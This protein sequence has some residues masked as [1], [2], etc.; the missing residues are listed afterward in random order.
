MARSP[1]KVASESDVTP[2]A[3]E[4]LDF[5]DDT[6]RGK[7]KPFIDQN[8]LFSLSLVGRFTLRANKLVLKQSQ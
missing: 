2:P 5:D 1:I 6:K 3:E 8:S 7:E 4:T